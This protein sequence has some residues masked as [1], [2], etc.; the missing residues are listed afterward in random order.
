MIRRT[1]HGVPRELTQSCK[2]SSAVERRLR[3][4]I[5]SH[6]TYGLGHLRRNLLLSAALGR[7]GP[8][9]D[10]LLITGSPRALS[11]PVPDHVEILKLPSV[12]KNEDGCYVPRNVTVS[13]DETMRGRKS[14]LRGGVV[15][16]D[17]DVLVVDHSPI[18]LRGELIPLLADLRH[19]T[20]TRLVLGLRDILDDPEHV[21][22]SWRAY[23]VHDVLE[24]LY[25]DIW[26]YGDESVFPLAELYGLSGEV[27]GRL[28]YLG[29][30]GREPSRGGTPTS[31]SRVFPDPHRPHLLCLVGGGG[32]GYP[33][34]TAFL[35]MFEMEPDRW[36]GTLVTG[37]FL[38]REH[39]N[40][41]SAQATHLP[42]IH[43]LRFTRAIDP[44]ISGSDLVIS[45]GGY[46]SV[47]EILSQGKK[48]VVIPRVFPRREQWIRATA[49]RDRGLLHV[50]EPSELSARTLFR[51]SAQVMR[52]APPP[53]P[54]DL[55]IRWG[56][57][58]EFARKMHQL[59]NNKTNRS[60]YSVDSPRP[61]LR[62]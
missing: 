61:C 60:E 44:L 2:S 22:E 1:E 27:A 7:N 46:N 6:D 29:Y 42:H 17:P 41:I 33:L 45:M 48:L 25:H 8:P 28:Q 47:L 55:G 34:A 53:A 54:Q 50:V 52:G 30:L 18:G 59:L 10:V 36:N 9:P 21:L 57:A 43:V 38:S 20:S 26:V 13:L 4:A 35:E 24:S 62:A 3:V 11:F 16:F 32:D 40:R 56:G 23:G 5:Y 31:A 49:F 15:Q 14:V 51:T 58:D 37:P 39:R 19:R 12:T